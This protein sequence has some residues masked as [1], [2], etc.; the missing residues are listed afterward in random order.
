MNS[1]K[2]STCC[3]YVEKPQRSSCSRYTTAEALLCWTA[4]NT[5]AV[6]PSMTQV[7]SP[8]VCHSWWSDCFRGD[9]TPD[10]Q[11]RLNRNAVDTL[12]EQRYNTPPI[13]IVTHEPYRNLSATR[14][15]SKL[16]VSYGEAWL[17]RAMHLRSVPNL[18]AALCS[19]NV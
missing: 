17:R 6:G 8:R 2:S 3:T 18:G 7:H 12:I 11:V 10:M 19:F 4:R 5:G 13:C 16:R 15:V 9:L 14:A 1:S